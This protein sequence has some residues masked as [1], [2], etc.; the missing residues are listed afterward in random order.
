M[1][2]ACLS[3]NL[4]IASSSVTSRKTASGQSVTQKPSSQKTR[5][6]KSPVALGFVSLAGIV[7]LVLAIYAGIT[8]SEERSSLPHKA[9]ENTTHSRV[10]GPGGEG[11]STERI[12]GVLAPLQIEDRPAVRSAYNREA[13]PHW[14]DLDGNGCNTRA[15]VLAEQSRMPVTRS[16]RCSVTYGEWFS[17]YDGETLTR[18]LDIDVDHVVPLANAWR[19]GA[20]AWS[21]ERRTHF[22]NE[23]EPQGTLLAVSRVSNRQKGDRGPEEWRPSREDAWCAYAQSWVDVKVRWELTATTRE[24]DALGQMLE[25]CS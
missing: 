13:F 18:A 23:M 6:P 1:W 8:N 25:R 9:A 3:R 12:R 20:W 2:G 5:P 22:A 16:G 21:T 24:R 19:S 4:G 17:V 11:W 7:A 10:G 15:D 14:R